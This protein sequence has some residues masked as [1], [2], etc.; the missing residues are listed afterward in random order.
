MCDFND[1]VTCE[2]VYAGESLENHCGFCG[3]DHTNP[4]DESACRTNQENENLR[5]PAY[6][7]PDG[8]FAGYGEYDD[9]CGDCGYDYCRCNQYNSEH[10]ESETW[11]I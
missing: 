6:D 10:N 5:N 9:C 11:G 2:D 8:I 4:D 7:G 3:T 1:D